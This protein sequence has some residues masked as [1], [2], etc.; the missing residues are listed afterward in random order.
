MVYNYC[1][2]SVAPPST[3][4]ESA[5]TVLITFLETLAYLID[6]Q[7]QIGIYSD[8]ELREYMLCDGYSISEAVE[9]LSDINPDLS[10]LFYELDEKVPFY[11]Y[12]D[13][14]EFDKICDSIYFFKDFYVVS[15]DDTSF[16]GLVDLLDFGL[17]SIASN[18][19]FRTNTLTINSLKKDGAWGEHN[20]Y[21]IFNTESATKFVHRYDKDNIC[22][23]GIQKTPN[24]EGWFNPL[25][26]ENKKH[27]KDKA[28]FLYAERFID[29][30][31]TSTKIKGTDYNIRELKF[32]SGHDT[33]GKIRVFY[34]FLSNR[35]LVL[36]LGF[37]KHAN[38]YR[39]EIRVAEQLID[40]LEKKIADDN[41]APS[42]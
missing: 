40:Q 29:G 39:T 8:L 12:I 10:Q 38:D 34:T 2:N 1:F 24:F 30:K 17:I 25:D 13:E 32:G 4:R 18:E 20:I 37:I 14:D 3:D 19:Y 5:N 41:S 33:F 7:E 9:V 27:I 16:L 31:S 35:E 23:N 15:G 6:E 26:G 42:A 28:N 22:F 11:Y 21:N 36:L